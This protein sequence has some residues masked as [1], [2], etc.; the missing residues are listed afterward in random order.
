MG[1][2]KKT[3][4]YLHLLSQ[5]FL[6]QG[7]ETE[8]A[9]DLLAGRWQTACFEK[10]QVIFGAGI[11]Q[12]CLGMILKGRA[13]AYSG[14][15]AILRGFAK[16]D[17]FG[18]ASLYTPAAEIISRIVA[19]SSGELMLIPLSAIQELMRNNWQV[20]EN[21]MLYLAQRIA[22]L[23][24]K[25]A[26][27][28]AGEAKN[29]LA[30]HIADNNFFDDMGRPVFSGNI[31]KL[32]KALDISR[33]SLYRALAQLMEQGVLHREGKSIVIDDVKRLLEYK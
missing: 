16:G 14:S 29:R 3:A 1:V 30:V 6:L 15:S 7:A 25:I 17:V 18:A 23:N 12:D 22:F 4:E 2:N 19:D 33:A 28:T 27:F 5:S 20:A 31:S 9:Q 8:A 10:G 24:S 21:Y 11:N 26:A 32:A 13:T